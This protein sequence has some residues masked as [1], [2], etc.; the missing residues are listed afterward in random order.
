MKTFFYTMLILGKMG[1]IYHPKMGNKLV[2]I[3]V[4]HPIRV[5][6]PRT[7]LKL[8]GNLLESYQWKTGDKEGQKT[9][10]RIGLIR[11]ALYEMYLY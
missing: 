8:I 10:I 11:F 9:V 5:K 4:Q 2:T 1:P 7:K 6:K 3:A